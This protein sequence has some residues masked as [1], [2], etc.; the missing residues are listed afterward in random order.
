MTGVDGMAE[1]VVRMRQWR[2]G[3]DLGTSAVKLVVLDG[4]GGVRG[5]SGAAYP[6]V[7]NTTGQAE[8]D[9]QAWLRALGQAIAA[10][11]ADCVA[12]IGAICVAG[13]M[14]TLVCL[15]ARGNS[16]GPAIT[17]QDGRADAM[18]ADRMKGGL[19]A[20]VYAR[21]G[22]PVDGRYLAPQFLHHF[23]SRRGDIRRILSAKDFIVHALTGRAVTD[24]S[25]AAGYGV[26]ALE[27]ES[28]DADLAGI[29]DLPMTMLPDLL[30]T[31]TA[32][33]TVV[34][35]SAL[36]FGLPAGIPVHNGAA[37]SAAGAYAMTGL[38]ANSA[39][40]AMGSSTII[41]GATPASHLDAKSRYL[42]TPHVSSGWYGREMDL[43]STGIGFAW[44]GRM[45]GLTTE[46]LE[47]EALTS[48]PAPVASPARPT[49]PAAANRARSGTHR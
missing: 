21:T 30:P 35:A 33:G 8:Q 46:A 13:Q 25:T 37:D 38:N 12:R 14:P 43:L 18:A 34:P 44:L 41:F 31:T 19:Y 3:I 24:P 20:H 40:I 45:L 15:D 7:S 26:Y 28:W 42:L 10:L 16:V 49:W 36:A 32:V 39:S 48:S 17:W 29:W 6:T 22:M 11:P 23:A 1:G 47:A 2:L 27:T 4:E 9:P 5:E